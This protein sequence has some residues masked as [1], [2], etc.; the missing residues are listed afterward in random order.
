MT[1]P[2]YA[3]AIS[4]WFE[5]VMK[6]VGIIP[7]PG[8]TSGALNGSA[9]LVQAISHTNGYRDSFET[10]FLRPFLGRPKLLVFNDTLTEETDFRW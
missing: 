6:V 9:S 10:A 1:Y 3:Q 8:F 5:K 7:V 4:T 2:N